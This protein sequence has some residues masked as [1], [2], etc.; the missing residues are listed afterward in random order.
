M[1]YSDDLFQLIKSMSKSEKGYFKKFASKHTIGEKNIYVRLFDAIDDLDHY[2]EEIIKENFKGEKFAGK[3]YSTKNYLFNF[4]LKALSAYHSEKVAVS[5]LSSMLIELNV[6]F[7]KGLYKQYKTRLRKAIELAQKHDK[8]Y[9]IAQLYDKEIKFLVAEYYEGI[10]VEKFIDLKN[11]ILQNLDDLKIDGAYQLLYYELFSI[12]KK[13]GSVRNKKDAETLKVFINHPLLKNESFAK[14]FNSKFHLY[15]ILG[16]Y[17]RVTND[18][19][20]WYRYRKMLFDLMESDFKYQREYYTSY[21]ST[22]NNYLNAC[23]QIGKYR[24]FES[25]LEKFKKFGEQF[26]NKK[27][28]LD[29]QI[30]IFLLISDLE[31]QY[32][33][34]TLQLEK[35]G[36]I[37]KGIQTGFK[38]FGSRINE[39]RKISLYNRLSYALFILKNFDESIGYINKILNSNEPNI[40]P[41]HHSFARVRNLILHYE[42]GN[43]DLLEYTVKNTKRYL[44]KNQRLYAFEKLIL[45]FIEKAMNSKNGKNL[46][47]LYLKLSNGL[48]KISDNP[49]EKSALEQFD[50]ISWLESKIRKVQLAAVLRKKAQENKKTGI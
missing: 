23:V 29:T 7:D 41:E 24:E 30:R 13:I 36:S 28:H 35:L 4:I 34:K 5:K 15:S 38:K 10:P 43:Y 3:L 22:F 40:E 20:N 37:I 21:I 6:L 46:D 14:N 26:E 31:L 17:Y 39:N 16:H 44:A 2:D 45:D 11:K 50:V 27:E 19:V 25:N 32:Y 9:F 49:F 48:K 42:M 8:G 12:L 33:L 18:T 47:E 1:K